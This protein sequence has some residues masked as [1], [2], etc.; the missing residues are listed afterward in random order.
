MPDTDEITKEELSTPP[1]GGEE[2][3]PEGEKVDPS[4]D[5]G[6]PE[7][8]EG[9]EPKE[10][11]E[12][13]TETVV[14]LEDHK[15]LQARLAYAERELRRKERE[16]AAPKD[17]SEP[18]EPK[19]PD[20]SS[21]PKSS[22]FE[23]YDD[24]VVAAASWDN[25]KRLEEKEIKDREREAE[26]KRLDRQSKM[27][28]V[29]SAEIAKDPDFVKKAY[30]PVAFV[31]GGKS[32]MTFEDLVS[33]SEQLVDLALHFGKHP[34]DAHRI[35]RLSPVQAAREIGRLE[36][37]LQNKVPPKTKTR[38][39]TPT[40]TVGG[41]EQVEKRLEDMTVAEHI[42]YQNKKEFGGG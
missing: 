37:K 15:K 34:E 42:A 1:E 11:E 7:P 40:K 8:K 18:K 16:N 6:E 17:E 25:A 38:A 13:K 28:A 21:R 26:N 3:P 35:I 2:T 9:D 23:D 24:F 12:P 30:I 27:D 39:P 36:T 10:G 5:G 19:Q 41:N 32:K 20:T 22:D 14:S 4:D 33:D 31:D 29:V